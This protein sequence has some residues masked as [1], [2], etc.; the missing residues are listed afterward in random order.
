MSRPGKTCADSSMKPVSHA[1]SEQSRHLNAAAGPVAQTARTYG[2]GRTPAGGRHMVVTVGAPAGRAGGPVGESRG[3]R[4]GEDSWGCSI[5]NRR[6]RPQRRNSGGGPGR[7]R[8]RSLDPGAPAQRRCTAG[9]S[10]VRAGGPSTPSSNGP[11]PSPAGRG[12]RQHNPAAPAVAG[13]DSGCSGRGVGTQMAPPTM[14]SPAQA[15][16]MT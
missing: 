6:A 3:A 8:P 12:G 11:A 7:S 14:R 15:T 5:P 16:S 10:A 4:R 13:P 2:S 1:A 9:T